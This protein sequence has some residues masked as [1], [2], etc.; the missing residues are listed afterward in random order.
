[1]H[2]SP[3]AWDEP[4][5]RVSMIIEGLRSL[6]GSPISWEKLSLSEW[7]AMVLGVLISEGVLLGA[8][9]VQW[10]A[11]QIIIVMKQDTMTLYTYNIPSEK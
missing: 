9:T 7:L 4:S 8:V 10:H 11:S 2:C 6:K 1:M 5:S 3:L